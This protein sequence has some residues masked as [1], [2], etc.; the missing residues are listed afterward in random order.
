MKKP[1]SEEKE[2]LL[3]EISALKQSV[4]ALEQSSRRPNGRDRPSQ[5]RID[6][7]SC[8]AERVL[9]V[10]AELSG[11]VIW[12]LDL[13]T[14]KISWTGAIEAITGFTPEAFKDVD[15]LKWEAMIHPDDSAKRASVFEAS[16]K[17]GNG[18]HC[19]YRFRKKDGG[20]IH[21]EDSGRMLS[22]ETGRRMLGILRDVTERK[23]M[24]VELKA[25]EQKYRTIF[26]NTGTPLLIS[27]EDTTILLVNREFE[28]QSGYRREE[29]EGK[30]KWTDFIAHKDDLTR[31]VAYNRRRRSDPENVP[32]AYEFQMLTKSGELRDVYVNVA[33]ISESNMT[34]GAMLD[35]TDRK[36]AER[37]L[38][39]SEQNL[40]TI[41]DNTY[42]AIFVHDTRGR[43][44]DVNQKL[45]DMY[46][47]SREQAL[48]STVLEDFS[49]PNNPL[50]E[51]AL[52]WQRVL[53]GESVAFEWESRRPNDGSVFDV[54]VALTGI[55]LGS[56]KAILANVRDISLRKAA[57]RTLK[58]SEEKFRALA[59]HN[60]D[61]IMRFDR[62][63]RHL[64]V[65][66]VVEQV[67][68][69][70][71]ADFIGKT[72]E[73]VGSP[74]AMHS[75]WDEA[76]DQVFHSG[77]VH[78]IELQRPGGQW[79]DWILIPESDAS[80]EINAVIASGRDVT[81]RKALEEQLRQSQK[82]DAIGQ[83]AGGVAHDFNNML[84]AILG[85]SDIV[86][87]S[88]SLDADDR[89]KLLEIHNAG[90]RAADLTGQ[91]LAFSRRQVLQLGPL[92]LNLIVMGLLKMLQ[93]LIGENIEL[94]FVRKKALWTVN[95]DKGQMEQ[96]LMNLCINARDAMP[97]GGKLTLE[98][99][100][101]TLDDAFCAQY[102]WA[103]P[104]QYVQLSVIDSGCGMSAET[105]R[106]VFEPFFTT[107]E[108]GRGTGLG[109]ATVYG[110][111][112]QHNGVIHVF[113][114]I[115][116]GSRFHVYLPVIET[117]GVEAMGEPAQPSVS[118]GHE[119]ILVAEDDAFI[120]GL[121]GHILETAGYRVLTAV[122]GEDAVRVGHDHGNKIDLLLLDVV[123]PKKSGREVFEAM[124]SFNPAI[125]CLFMSGYSED[126]VRNNFFLE[127]GCALIRKP[128]KN[129]EL[130]RMIRLELDRPR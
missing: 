126:A 53:K 61:T 77:K 60:I 23:R 46:G 11:Q 48:K 94:T 57:M 103:E 45:L 64:Y 9:Q 95:A 96:A 67:T 122:D 25:S 7:A 50:D 17:G 52:R 40:R 118:G 34:L 38:K 4:K 24:A 127:K 14:G 27:R 76:I 71:A 36:R 47:V 22:T 85:Y 30:R 6:P 37:A 19:E 100:N 69:L 87:S 26:E 56:R 5:D 109:L 120:R 18:Y 91:L 113:S 35:I 58:E 129:S 99:G 32:D 86:L 102:D 111:V 108:K 75:S 98:T 93:R 119:T 72:G 41:F 55:T 3:A 97:Q 79:V 80:G 110:I 49:S 112:R 13:E 51:M 70:P 128:F 59:E 44:L 10:T 12:D 88:A 39:A 123:M 66:P 101:V 21:V 84:Q 114:E 125:K 82:M 29:L 16:I 107:K 43:I 106:K 8:D 90:Q 124:Q 74:E 73:E 121:A 116:K 104:G 62:Q 92:D 31:M 78:R 105:R 33:L 117:I 83:L 81:D 28:H 130:L 54:E 42:D 89:E 15:L 68:G 63:H 1:L 20:H 65:N 2:T 115:G